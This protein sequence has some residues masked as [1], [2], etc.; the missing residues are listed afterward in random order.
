M[1]LAAI[2]FLPFIGAVIPLLLANRERVHITMAT[3]LVALA[4][5]AFLVVEAPTA[6]AGNTALYFAEWLPSLGLHI[7]FRLDGLA[8]FFAGLILVIGILVI[9]YAHYYL[10]NKDSASRFFSCLLLFMGSML[11]IVTADNLILMWFFWELTSISSFLLIGY[12]SH[13]SNARR[14]ARMALAV[15]GA[16]GLHC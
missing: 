11:G 10:S 1:N 14:G 6:L 7:A 4:S 8:L 9:I 15:T 12:W 3:A 2:V 13:Q 16:G 5:L